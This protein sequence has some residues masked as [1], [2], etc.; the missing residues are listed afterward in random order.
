MTAGLR[1]RRATSSFTEPSRGREPGV[2][3]VDGLRE[4]KKGGEETKLSEPDECV[5]DETVLSRR[6]AG[7]GQ[8]SA[9]CRESGFMVEEV[10][11]LAARDGDR[12]D[13]AD[14]RL[15]MK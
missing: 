12:A 6:L 2:E 15:N 1:G 8:S 10:Q 4:G 13:Q 7:R 5:E 11:L 3:K 9:S 14:R